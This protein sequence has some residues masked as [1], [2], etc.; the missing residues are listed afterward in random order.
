MDPF[1]KLIL[2]ILKSDFLLRITLWEKSENARG[3]GG[4]AEGP[5]APQAPKNRES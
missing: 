3:T 4:E 1:L 5:E 2:T